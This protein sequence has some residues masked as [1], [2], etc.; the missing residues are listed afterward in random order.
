MMID[1]ADLPNNLLLIGH[2]RLE[3]GA[4]PITRYYAGT[5]KPLRDVRL[6]SLGDVD[7]AVAA[8]RAA[9]PAWRAMSPSAR[10]DVMLKAASLLVE[11]GDRLAMLAAIDAGLA[12]QGIRGFVKHS[13]EWLTYYAGWIDKA[14]GATVPMDGNSIDYTRYEPYGVIGVI[15]PANAAVSAMVL[16]PLLAAGNCAVVKPSEFTSLVTAEYLQVF[17]DAG[18]P[19]GVLNSVPGGAAEGEALV[20]HTG[21]DKIHFTGSCAVGAKVSALASSNLKPSALELGGKS[22]NIVFPD[23][24]LDVAADITMRALVRQTGQSCV[25][26][27]RIIVHE[28]VADELLARTIERTQKQKIG[29]PLQADTVVGP[30]VSA[31]SCARIQDIIARAKSEGQGRLALGGTRIGGDLAGGYFIQPTIFAD[32]KN[33]SPLAQQ[34]TFGPVISFITFRSDDE[35]VA[36]ANASPYGLAAYIQTKDIR[37][38]HRTAA[39]LDVG[40]IW[41]NGAVG[42]LPGGPFGGYKESGFGRV[43]GRDGLQEFSRAKN[44]WIGL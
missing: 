4:D 5:G 40:V 39:A 17:L 28:S 23:S 6:A 38:A 34:E 11:R 12:A 16:A 35:A 3:G 36:L 27:T 8:A 22:A 41:V 21:I 2:A 14:G 29:D 15:S 31:A 19:P 1:I 32:V 33:D 18:V 9:F 25:A 13:A 10:R 44:V 7:A 43:G 20:R 42:I 30:V 24:D 37:R 26:G